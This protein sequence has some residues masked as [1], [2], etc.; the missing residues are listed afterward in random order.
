MMNLTVIQNQNF[1]ASQQ[2]QVWPRHQQVQ[3]PRQYRPHGRPLHG[4]PN[5]GSHTARRRAAL[6]FPSP[7]SMINLHL[8]MPDG[9]FLDE[10]ITKEVVPLPTDSEAVAMKLIA[11]PDRLSNSGR[12]RPSKTLTRWSSL[13][14][15]S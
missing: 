8:Y 1:A 9:M 11:G 7:S 3:Y 6:L 4:E 14:R 13:A 12:R 5:V 10:I 2:C 15:I